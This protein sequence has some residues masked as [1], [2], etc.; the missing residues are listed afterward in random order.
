MD[1]KASLL[2][3]ATLDGCTGSLLTPDAVLRRVERDQVHIR[4]IGENVDICSSGSIDARM[5]RD[6][7]NTLS[8]NEVQAIGDQDLDAGADDARGLV[9]CSLVR[10]PASGSR[11]GQKKGEDP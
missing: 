2:V 3:H 4:V 1:R 8:R 5:V 9:R 11:N 7:A 10:D 6:Q